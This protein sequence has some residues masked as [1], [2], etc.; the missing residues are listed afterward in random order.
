MNLKPELVQKWILGGTITFG[1]I[2]AATLL[3]V[4]TSFENLEL[5]SYDWRFSLRGPI[6]VNNDDIV[7]V[8]LDQ[9]T[10]DDLAYRPPLPRTF[11]AKLID[12]LTR[13]QARLIVFDVL[14]TEPS[15]NDTGEDGALA[16]AAA[17]SQRVVFAGKM[18]TA[19]MRGGSISMTLNRPLPSLLQS[20]PNWA[21]VN[22][23]E[24]QDGFVRRYLLYVAI[25]E[26]K[27]FPLALQAYAQTRGQS[28]NLERFF[29]TAPLQFN[30]NDLALFDAN[31]FLINYRGP[32]KTYPTY[33]LAAV[34]DDKEFQLPDAE[35]DTDSFEKELLPTGVF[36]NKI[37]L[38][39][40][41]AEELQ[42]N[43]LTPFFSS[44]GQ[45]R[46]L[47]G[48]EVH[49]NALSTLLHGDFIARTT[50]GVNFLI[51]AANALLTLFFVL[52]A[53]AAIG[54]IFAF[55]QIVLMLVVACLVFSSLQLWIP[56][57]APITVAVLSY[58]GNITPVLVAERRERYRTKKIFEQYVSAS[59]VNS[60]L[61]SGQNP[62]F[63]GEKRWLTVLFS[64][65]R[66]FT[67][68]C[69]KHKPEVV[70]QRLNEYL[71]LMTEVIFKYQGTLDKFVGDAIVALFGAPYVFPNHAEMAC[72]TACEM[73]EQLREMQKSWSA[74]AQD[75]FQIGIGVN[76]G[77]MIVGN[78]GAQQ[79]FDY[80]AI[81]DEVNL[82]A[83][84]EG[85]N[86]QYH[87]AIIISESTYR[88]VK[89]RAQVRELDLVRVK[90]KSKP[91]K[92]YELR[93]MIP[94]PDIEQDLL[95]DTYT[96]GLESYKQRQWYRALKEFQSILRYFPTDGPTRVYIQRCFDFIASP[97]PSNWDGVY[98]FK[99]K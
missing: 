72:A 32:E 15:Q 11:Y 42:D 76:T 99:T 47:P 79:R 20:S 23:D 7:I 12:N 96:R 82:G 3:S 51:V 67:T 55:G 5:K 85:A 83:R 95:V 88:Q 27:F 98:E 97:P 25:D 33:S 48:V 40:A 2:L 71:T 78:L 89:K 17:R 75:Y 58:I 26:R 57:V 61:A 28:V 6:S 56:V 18:E 81:G 37:V 13:A 16:Q 86:K 60:I 74:Q 43:K 41:T 91:V 80:T 92:I 22:I 21:V 87:T 65:I 52:R 30:G 77:A 9:Q 1:A 19:N 10:F 35:L 53:R 66:G 29:N 8:A 69:E 24:D 36:K 44:R 70:V 39:G 54:I 93:D 31:S 46:K 62:K 94:L 90:G 38:I 73:I 50:P 59:V 34:L 63:G 68:Y 64:D 14:F 84:L 4:T 45:Q 49:A